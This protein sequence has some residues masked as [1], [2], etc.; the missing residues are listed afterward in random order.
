M[1]NTTFSG[2]VRSE[3][4]FQSITKSTTTGAVFCDELKPIFGTDGTAE[5]CISH[6]ILLSWLVSNTVCV[7]QKFL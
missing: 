4:G 5:S 7:R 1:A 3:N 2:P 6:V